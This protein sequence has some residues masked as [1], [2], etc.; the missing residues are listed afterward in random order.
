MKGFFLCLFLPVFFSA[1]DSIPQNHRYGLVDVAKAD[2]S[3]GILILVNKK[4][5]LA[6]GYR[7]YDLVPIDNRYNKG[8]M[9]L[10][11]KEAAAAFALMCRKAEEDSIFLWNISAYRSDTVQRQLYDNAVERRGVY[12]A[13]RVSARPGHSEH[14]TGLTADFNST[15]GSFSRTPQAAWLRQHAHLFGFIERYPRHK[16]DITGYDHE[17]WHFRY[18]GVEAATTIYTNK[19]TLEE[20]HGTIQKPTR[21][22]AR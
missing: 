11:R 8:I 2:T 17:P 12:R 5:K 15:H 3:L 7:P 1:A 14:Q 21:N 10:L 20:Y 22:P 4:H 18:V 16:E 6:E 19:L 9:N 13:D